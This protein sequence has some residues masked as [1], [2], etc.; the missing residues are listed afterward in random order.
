LVSSRGISIGQFIQELTPLDASLSSFSKK[1]MQ[2]RAYEE[3]EDVVQLSSQGTFC[4][5]IRY[6]MFIFRFVSLGSEKSCQVESGGE[7]TSTQEMS[8]VWKMDGL[9]LGWRD[10]TTKKREFH[11][12]GSLFGKVPERWCK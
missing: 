5:V 9:A 4:F 7:G 8:K 10:S 1:Y 12:P 2:K 11:L 6:L 3:I